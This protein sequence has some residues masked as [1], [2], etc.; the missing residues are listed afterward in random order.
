MLT[1]SGYSKSLKNYAD[2]LIFILVNAEIGFMSSDIC[3]LSK[4]NDD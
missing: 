2:S 1:D 4:F 3:L